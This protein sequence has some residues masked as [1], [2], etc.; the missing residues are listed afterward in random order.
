MIPAVTLDGKRGKA[1]ERIVEA[2]VLRRYKEKIDALVEE[3]VRATDMKGTGL[4][5][6]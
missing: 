5:T 3:K 4:C 1:E 2:E 6:C